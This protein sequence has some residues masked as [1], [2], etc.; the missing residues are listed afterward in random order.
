[1]A[2]MGRRKVLGLLG[3]AAT[4]WPLAARAQQPTMPVI[5]FMHAASADRFPHLVAAFRKGLK[6]VGYVEGQNVAIEFRWA[7]GQYDRLPR[8]AADL[9]ARQVSVL[10]ATG[11]DRSGLAAKAATA[12]T[13]ILF[14]I[15]GDPVQLGLVASLNRPGGNV[16]G[17]TLLSRDLAPK[18]LELLHELVPKASDIAL[19]VNPTSPDAD[20]Q[21]RD[22][23]T[24]ASAV[25]MQVRVF[26]AS[27]DSDIDTAFAAML[28]QGA[29]ALVV[30]ADPFFTNRRDRLVTLANRHA[31]PAIYPFRE[32]ATVGGLITYGADIAEA[33]REIGVYTGRILNGQR[34][35][36]LPVLQPT[37]FDLVIN[38]R[39]AKALGITVPLT[40][41]V[42]A[43]DVVE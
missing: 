6:E 17:T 23:Q 35:A 31:I 24:A 21:S 30:Q 2:D 39:T 7:E 9:V 33:F 14:E 15:G 37:K 20:A 42:A 19:L 27:N 36:D 16:T 12:T 10:A 11:G 22:L 1:M 28:G 29:N 3:G 40:L 38:L 18:R 41:Q 4:A 26:P 43:N 34:P 5:G 13:P 32:F 8:F 25:G